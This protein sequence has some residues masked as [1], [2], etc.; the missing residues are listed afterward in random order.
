MT[1]MDHAGYMHMDSSYAFN[2]VL[3]ALIKVSITIET[4]SILG[5]Y[6]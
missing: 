3:E 6:K 2:H 1:L 4:K 5:C